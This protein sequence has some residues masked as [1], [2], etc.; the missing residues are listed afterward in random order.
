MASMNDK[1]MGGRTVDFP[2]AKNTEKFI[3]STV[4]RGNTSRPECGNQHPAMAKGLAGTTSKT[5]P[6]SS[7]QRSTGTAIGDVD[8]REALDEESEARIEK[9]TLLDLRIDAIEDSITEDGGFVDAPDDGRLYG[10][11]SEDW[12]EVVILST[13]WND[14]TGKPDVPT[15]GTQ[16][17]VEHDYR[18]P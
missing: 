3:S 9:D 5:A 2:S 1:R 16:S 7:R 4:G 11:Q 12:A 15:R 10:R 17:A 6:I 13:A 8:G 14:I 18:H